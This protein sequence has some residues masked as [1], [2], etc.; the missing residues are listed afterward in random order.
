MSGIFSKTTLAL[1]RELGA[2][3][4]TQKSPQVSE[5]R[6]E[7]ASVAPLQGLPWLAKQPPSPKSVALIGSN[8]GA[9]RSRSKLFKQVFLGARVTVYDQIGMGLKRPFESGRH[10][11]LVLL[12]AL[13]SFDRSTAPLAFVNFISGLT[14]GGRLAIKDSM[15]AGPT[16]GLN[17]EVLRE[18]GVATMSRPLTDDDSEGAWL[19][20]LTRERE[21]ERLGAVAK[22][23]ADSLGRYEDVAGEY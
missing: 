9:I 5:K 23:L 22:E 1:S 12:E 16:L 4:L 2:L 8:W 21:S 19:H 15:L 17:L 13:R 20:V 6:R 11:L 18:L 3:A 7:P 14:V 10:D